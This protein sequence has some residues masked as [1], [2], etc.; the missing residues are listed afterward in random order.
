MA[1]IVVGFA[2]LFAQT[3]SAVASK[4]R[5]AAIGSWAQGPRIGAA[6]VRFVASVRQVTDG[7]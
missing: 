1:R 2:V 6:K 3:C 5:T 7:E 4:P